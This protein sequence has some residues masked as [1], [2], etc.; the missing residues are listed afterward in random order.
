M[1]MMPPSDIR[2]ERSRHPGWPVGRLRPGLA[3]DLGSVRT[4]AWV[5]GRGVILDV[6]TVTF[7]GAGATYPVRRGAVVDPEGA[8]RML[9]RLLS[10]R[11]PRFARPLVVLTTPVLGGP[12][13]REAALAAL[14]VLRPRTVLTVPGAK[15]VALATRGAVSRPVVVV[16]VGAHLTEVALLIDGAVTDAYRTALGTTDLDAST[17]THDL[18]RSVATMVTEMLRLDHTGQAVDALQRGV[19][20]AGGGA[21]HPECVYDIAGRL[22]APVRPVAAPHTAAL[23]GAALLLRSA[24]GHPTTCAP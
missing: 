1:T 21:S 15:A 24:A 3:L 13:H 2:Y 4:R 19:L 11:L 5:P 16:D 20:L 12:S 23:R 14:Q 6:P 22:G 9:D 17:T 7:P 18:G 8:A 10:H